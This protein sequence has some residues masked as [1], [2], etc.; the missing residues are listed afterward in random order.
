MSNKTLKIAIRKIKRKTKK[1]KSKSLL[2]QKLSNQ[3]KFDFIEKIGKGNY[4]NVYLVKNKQNNKRTALKLEKITDDN[5]NLLMNEATILQNL[6][7]NGCKVIPVI[8]WFGKIGKT[9]RGLS[10][11][12][13][14]ATLMDIHFA[15]D[16]EIL[17]IFDEMLDVLDEVH[18]R[19]VVHCDIKP[20]NFMFDGNG[21]IRLIDF[22]MSRFFVDGNKKFL[23]LQKN[24]TNDDEKILYGTTNYASI[25]MHQKM[26]PYP[27][28]D[29]CSLVFVLFY[30]LNG[31]KKIWKSQES[32]L[33]QKKQLLK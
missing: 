23:P 3:T 12:Y 30:L 7:L 5:G 15:N 14:E 18:Y 11:T 29:I 17:E 26:F 13:F 28:D 21:N 10:M 24:I 31:K 16:N 22:G 33:T 6:H 8:D 32:I 9:Y 19:G 20:Q 27:R 4:S 1:G 25:W 2:L